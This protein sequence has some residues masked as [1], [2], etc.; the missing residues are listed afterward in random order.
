MPTW[1]PAVAALN[2]VP[3]TA[4]TVRD[5]LGAGTWPGAVVPDH[6]SLL[7]AV[8]RPLALNPVFAPLAAR[9]SR[10]TG[11]VAE[12]LATGRCLRERVGAESED[13]SRAPG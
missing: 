11:T 12:P 13:G 6:L 5:L 9:R 4:S 7:L 1:L 10:V 2:P 3:A 8:A